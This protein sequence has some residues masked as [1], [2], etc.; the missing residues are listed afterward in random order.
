MQKTAYLLLKSGVY[1]ALASD[2]HDA[3]AA[4]VVLDP[5]KFISN[6]LLQGL[7]DWDGASHLQ[8]SDEELVSQPDLF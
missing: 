5:E 2:L 6:P 7:V 3:Q 8:E 1:S 4:K